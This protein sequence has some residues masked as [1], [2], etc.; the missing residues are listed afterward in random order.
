M[1]QDMESTSWRSG[2]SEPS[3]PGFGSEPG[4]FPGD[5]AEQ[6]VD[7]QGIATTTNST[8]EH[9]CSDSRVES[10]E[11]PLPLHGYDPDPSAAPR[12]LEG[13]LAGMPSNLSSSTT[14]SH[15][16]SRHAWEIGLLDAGSG[17]NFQ[18]QL[19]PVE[20]YNP[21]QYTGTWETVELAGNLVTPL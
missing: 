17:E 18:S 5:S 21:Q 13:F 7:K 19:Q 11:L 1:P 8:P 14:G 4:V 20:Y 6:H 2:L 3:M 9:L 12:A 10:I 15:N 16:I